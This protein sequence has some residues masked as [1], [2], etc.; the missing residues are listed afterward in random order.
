MD[1]PN[2]I[3]HTEISEM[4]EFH[5]NIIIKITGFLVNLM[6]EMAPEI[7]GPYVVY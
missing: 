3:K 6:M 5:E 4:E 7:Y 1:L 2:A